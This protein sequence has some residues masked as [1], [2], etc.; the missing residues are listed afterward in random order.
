MTNKFL[1]IWNVDIVGIL[2]TDQS[3]IEIDNNFYY[4]FKWRKIL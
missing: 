2:Q 4:F 1:F 3:V